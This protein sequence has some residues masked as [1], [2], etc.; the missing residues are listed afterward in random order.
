[1]QK[2]TKKFHLPPLSIPFLSLLHETK[3]LYNFYKRV[4]CSIVKHN[5]GLEY[6]L[7]S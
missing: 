4:Q 2:G 1:M 5:I 7:K 3:A 6:A